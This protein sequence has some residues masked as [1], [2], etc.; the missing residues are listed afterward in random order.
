MTNSLSNNGTRT[1]NNWLRITG[2]ICFRLFCTFL[3]FRCYCCWP[4]IF[5]YVGKRG[6]VGANN[7][8]HFRQL[9]WAHILLSCKKIFVA[10]FTLSNIFFWNKITAFLISW[11]TKLS[12][13]NRNGTVLESYKAVCEMSW[14]QEPI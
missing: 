10:T 14:R 3:Y 4:H 7:Y 5:L 6:K 8:P 12:K 1:R 13:L 2:I 11:G 9:L